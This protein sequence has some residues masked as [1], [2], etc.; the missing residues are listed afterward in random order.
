MKNNS[1]G[2]NNNSWKGGKKYHSK[3]YILIWNPSHPNAMKGG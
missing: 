3:G 1:K 2:P